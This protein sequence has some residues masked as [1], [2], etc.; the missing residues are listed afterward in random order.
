MTTTNDPTETP[1]PFLP[2]VEPDLAPGELRLG[3][4]SIY[5]DRSRLFGALARAQANFAPIKRSRTV[6][7]RSD[8]GD[9]TFDYAPLEEVIEATR[10]ALA[11]EGLA[12]PAFLADAGE[13]GEADLHT[14]LTHESGACIHVVERLPAVGKAQ[15]RGSQVTY[16][17][18]YQY[19]C[20]TG[21]SPEFDDDGNAADGNKV[22]GMQQKDQPR[23]QAPA[24]KE[25]E[26]K[27]ERTTHVELSKESAQLIKGAFKTLGIIAGPEI[28][29]ITK[30]AT[31]KLSSDPTFSE[32]DGKKLFSKLHAIAAQDGVEL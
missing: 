22:E 19:Q 28:Q 16:R 31:G 18:R 3:T 14:L 23:R 12:V 25:P 10:P 9:Y 29:A 7:V 6:K 30:E 11:A 4:L 17:R 32:E 1:I 27:P 2:V 20:V 5:G 24:P 13:P 21:T 8:K 15:E 26:P